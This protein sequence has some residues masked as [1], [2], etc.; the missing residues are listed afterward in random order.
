MWKDC[1][2]C[3][4]Q[5]LK[6]ASKCEHCGSFQN[7]LGILGPSQLILSLIIALISVSTLFF[8][9]ILTNFIHDSN[10]TATL[11]EQ[12]IFNIDCH[13]R[14]ID[15]ETK[16]EYFDCGYHSNLNLFV[17]NYGEKKG[18]FNGGKI[19]LLDQEKKTILKQQFTVKPSNRIIKP[20]SFFLFK[21]RLELQ[22]IDVSNVSTGAVVDVNF[23]KTPDIVFP[24]QSLETVLIELSFL[25][26]NG[27]KT[28]QTI[29][30][31]KDDLKIQ[32]H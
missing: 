18:E 12:V 26:S 28:S 15:N 2:Y 23:K 25:K 30:I 32:F 16:Q 5:I 21:K 1:K 10:I 13:N 20:D 6:G 27:E 11:Q 22:I 31:D 24:M 7:L 17:K 9:K 8:D 14:L 19:S 29:K 3:K 4:K